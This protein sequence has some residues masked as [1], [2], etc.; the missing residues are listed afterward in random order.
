MSWRAAA[1]VAI[2]AFVP[3]WA[4]ADALDEQARRVGKQL[5]CPVCA[6]ASV[7]DSPADLAVQMRTTIRR[8][9]EQGETDD[10]IVAY[11]VERYGD[12]VL[13]EPPRRGIGLAVWLLPLVALAGGAAMVVILVRRWSRPT[14]A[15]GTIGVTA[16][17]QHLDAAIAEYQRFRNRS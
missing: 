8:K 16:N 10:Q 9:L 1:I 5:Q 15:P 12:S 2:L 17:A 13:V 7:A 3:A 14:A 6:G 4:S 11:F